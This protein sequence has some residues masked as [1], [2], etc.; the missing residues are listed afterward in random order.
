MFWQH[1]LLGSCH[2]VKGLATL[3]R[4]VAFYLSEKI[5]SE[6]IWTYRKKG[7]CVFRSFAENLCCLPLFKCAPYF[8]FWKS[9]KQVLQVWI[10]CCELL[11]VLFVSGNRLLCRVQHWLWC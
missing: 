1:F 9:R 10:G 11:W 3:V 6:M 5:K 4:F 8:T 2:I 7:L